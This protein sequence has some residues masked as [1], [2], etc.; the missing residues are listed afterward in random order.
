MSHLIKIKMLICFLKLIYM[1]ISNK[2]YK[3]TINIKISLEV[4]AV[5]QQ[6]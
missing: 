6:D 1:S 4:S 2:I 5:A 3:Y